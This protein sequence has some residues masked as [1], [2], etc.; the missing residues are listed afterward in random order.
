MVP[1]IGAIKLILL[2]FQ[3]ASHQFLSDSYLVSW[4]HIIVDA[5]VDF[6]GICATTFSTTVR[7]DYNLCVCSLFS[8]GL[9]H[10]CTSSLG[11]VLAQVAV[12]PLTD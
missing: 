3:L 1:S 2:D 4:P 7:L 6:A 9:F 5:L 10:Y 11:V 8:F 12:V